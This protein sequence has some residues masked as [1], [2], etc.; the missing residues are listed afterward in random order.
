MVRAISYLY[1][2]MYFQDPTDASGAF[3]K[4]AS[5]VPIVYATRDAKSSDIIASRQGRNTLGIVCEH[6][7]ENINAALP[8]LDGY[9]RPSKMFI[10]KQVAQGLA[11]RYYLYTQQWEKAAAMAAEARKG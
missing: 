9:V 1:L 4:E 7:E 8:L 6:I 2:M 5:G 11:A 3:N 10:D